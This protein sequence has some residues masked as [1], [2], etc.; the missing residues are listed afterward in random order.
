MDFLSHNEI[1]A[2]LLDINLPD[3]TGI[4]TITKV[5]QNFPSYTVV[6]L[7]GLDDDEFSSR[8]VQAGA[9]DYLFKG[10]VTPSLLC[11]SIRYAI[12]RQ[13]LLAEIESTRQQEQKTRELSTLE[14]LSQFSKRTSIT[15]EIYGVSSLR[16]NAPEYF[17]EIVQRYAALMD[18]ALEQRMFQ[19]EDKV[20]SELVDLA[21]ELG[22]IRTNAHDVVEIH[23]TALKI[24]SRSVPL[25]KSQAYIEEGRIMLVELMGNLAM[26]YR[27]YYYGESHMKNHSKDT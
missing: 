20:T 21:D 11:H 16:K 4:D 17:D 10:E 22:S 1:D 15:S 9:Q 24:K 19:M 13:H 8:V 23:T 18:V 25:L 5:K 2:I 26:F 14:K 6:A 7:T 27:N 3:S 12:E